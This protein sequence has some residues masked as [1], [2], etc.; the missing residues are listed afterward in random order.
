MPVWMRTLGVV[1]IFC[2]PLAR[3]ICQDDPGAR[4]SSIEHYRRGEMYLQED[5]LQ[6]GANEFRAALNGNLDPTWTEV[7]S[8][9]QLAR[10]FDVTGRHNRAINEYQEAARTGDNTDGALDIANKY[11]KDAGKPI[12]LPVAPS[13]IPSAE[14]IQT[15]DPE[16]TEEARIAELEGTVVLSG[17]IDPGGSAQNLEVLEPL[18]LGLDENA[19]EAVKQWRFKPKQDETAQIAVDFRLLKQS[20]WHLIQAQ[21]GPPAGTSRPVFVSALYPIGAGIGPQ[22]MEEG[23]VLAAIGRLATA[24]VTFDVDEHGL[25]VHLQVLDSSEPVWG[26]EAMSVVDQWRFTPGMK[27]GIAVA[28][29]CTL[30][31]VWGQRKLTPGLERQLHDVLAAR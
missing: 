21:F 20:R 8:H 6:S 14:P 5:N 12:F 31:L 7:W 24:K 10:I 17:T 1:A 26:T 23:S 27:N 4:P 2:L 9:I 15:T 25:P 22:A 3:G 29:P 19:I 28:V 18:G 30:E 16:Y 13:R 11:L